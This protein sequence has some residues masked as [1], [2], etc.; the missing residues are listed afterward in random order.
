M[1]FSKSYLVFLLF[2]KKKKYLKSRIKS[3]GR[4][5]RLSPLLFLSAQPFPRPISFFQPQPRQSPPPPSLCAREQPNRAAGPLPLSFARDRTRAGQL[6]SCSLHMRS[7][8]HQ[9]FAS[10]RAKP[11]EPA[12]LFFF[13]LALSAKWPR[14][15]ACHVNVVVLTDSRPCSFTTRHGS[16]GS[17]PD[18]SLFQCYKSPP[19]AS[20]SS[21]RFPP[22]KP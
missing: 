1:V 18:S 21:P 4:F 9:P 8:P 11:I 13:S 12:P 20:I 16:A 22:P 15:A 10:S 19:S 7:S 2:S 6:V 17:H 14:L 5:S 3:S